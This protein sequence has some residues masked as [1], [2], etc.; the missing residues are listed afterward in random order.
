MPTIEDQLAL[1]DAMQT[2]G[3]ET[4]LKNQRK[5]EEKGRGSEL[6]YSR[7]LMQQYL[8]PMVEALTLL[9][10]Q[11]GPGKFGVARAL[12]QRIEPNKAMFLT[13]KGLFNAFTI[14]EPVASTAARIGRMVEDEIRFARF[15][16]LYSDYYDTII[17][18][19]KRKGTKDYRYMHRV[20]THSAN[21]QNEGNGDGWNVWSQRERIDVGMRLL[22]IVL[23]ESDLVYKHTGYKGAKTEVL[24]IPTDAAKEWIDKH[25]AHNSV[26][27]AERAPCIIEPDPWRSI[28]EGGYYSPMLRKNTMMVKTSGKLQ[29]KLLERNDLTWVQEAINAQMR[30]AWSVNPRVLDVLKTVWAKDLG[31]GIPHSEKL[32]P[33]DCPVPT[34]EELKERGTVLTAQEL[35]LLDEWKKVA[36]EVYTM[37]KERIAQAFQTTR[38]I[39]MANQYASYHSFWYVWYADFRGRLYTATAGFSPQGPDAAKGILRFSEGKP[40]GEDGLTWL[41]IHIANRYGFDKEDF[42]ERVKWT[43]ERHAVLLQIADDPIGNI[44]HWKDA[45]K[46]YQFLAAVFEYAECDALV[47]LGYKASEYVS[48]LP[49]GLDGSCNGLQN[50]SAMLRDEIGGAATNLVPS[51]KPADIYSEVAKVATKKL[52]ELDKIAIEVMDLVTAKLEAQDCQE[53]KEWLKYARE[54]GKGSL[55]RSLAKRPVMTLPYGATRQSCTQYIFQDIIKNKWTKK[56]SMGPWSAAVWLCHILWEAIGEVVVAARSAMSWLQKMSNG[57]T[58]INKPIVWKTKDGFVAVQ[59]SREIE[60]VKI[61][62]QLAGRF[63]VKIGSF[64]DRLDAN[65]QRSGISPNFVHSQD[66]AHMRNT[67]RL[68]AAHGIHNIACI[69]DDYG[70]YACDTTRFQRLIRD[71]FVD[72]YQDF[73]PLQQ[74]HD[75]AEAYGAKV[76][77][78]PSKGNLDLQLVRESRHFFG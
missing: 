25:E 26:M 36:S 69:H 63:Q 4:Y 59:N 64:T 45:D 73:D 15:Q 37:E 52:E 74:L 22:D 29:Q 77:P 68:A 17:K 39:K 30:V 5:A 76:P 43:E 24:L 57:M 23:E 2:S 6:D 41:K 33:P 61:N 66:A 40:L 31:V 34:K 56:F 55:P 65:K 19:F 46:P 13:L 60:T 72:M 70:T 3:V 67:I 48:R 47:S 27:F 7:R 51:E 8:P 12:L 58:K 53:A 49:I 11:K 18:D 75:I 16:E 35:N 62:T 78:V 32:T 50:F 21:N 14:E 20:L 54:N 71:A 42:P 10:T 1:E 28:S 9:Q 38:I 44:H